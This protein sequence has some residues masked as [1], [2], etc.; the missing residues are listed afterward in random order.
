M[1]HEKIMAE[2]DRS[3][4]AMQILS[5]ADI[6][7]LIREKPTGEK[8]EILQKVFY[9]DSRMMAAKLLNFLEESSER[10]QSL[11]PFF[12]EIALKDLRFATAY[13]RVFGVGQ[14][15][16]RDLDFLGILIDTL[17][18]GILEPRI[19]AMLYVIKGDE[20]IK[21]SLVAFWEEE[22]RNRNPMEIMLFESAIRVSD[23]IG[24]DVC[25]A[26]LMKNFGG[27]NVYLLHRICLALRSFE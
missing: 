2:M 8:I 25:D 11:L 20:E 15:A 22:K 12:K 18:C 24:S 19:E 27:E 17:C 3:T 1:S 16:L 4:N 23:E 9:S 10:D 21:A 7:D 6:Y 14:D 5:G 26:K 13:L